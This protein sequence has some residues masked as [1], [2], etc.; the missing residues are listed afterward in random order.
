MTKTV[1]VTG[2]AGTV[3]TY[4]AALAGAKG[5]RVIATDVRATAIRLPVRGETRV[6]DLTDA[7]QLPSLVK[8]CDAVIHTAALLN[9]AADPAALSVVNTEAVMNLYRAAAEAGVQRFVHLSGAR[10]YGAQPGP[11]DEQA[12]LAPRGPYALSKLAAEVF[13]REQETGPDW[14]ILRAAPIY[15]RRGRHFAASLLAV[16]P[17]LKLTMPLL[18]RFSGGPMGTMAHAEDVARALLFVLDRPDAAGRVLNVSDGDAVS[19]GERLSLT[20]DA[21]QLRTSSVASAFGT[22]LGKFGSIERVYRVFDRMGMAGWRAVVARHGLKHALRPRFD[23]EVLELV[24]EDLVVDASAL[25]E[26]GWTPRFQRFEAGWSEVLRM[27]Q[28]ERWVP[29]Y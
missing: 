21:Y 2:A 24:H 11:M 25:R 15:G 28:A 4:V 9:V 29:R 23:R 6:A 18:P 13:L 5:H 22:W 7:T 26:M 19:I 1:L 3:G 20:F 17:I 8:G 14:T 16:G 12:P 10:L 27:Y